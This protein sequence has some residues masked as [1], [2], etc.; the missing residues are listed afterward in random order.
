MNKSLHSTTW[1]GPS[2]QKENK[3]KM[4][5]RLKT[6]ETYRNHIDM[7]L[8]KSFLG[9]L[10][11]MMFLSCLSTLWNTTVEAGEELADSKSKMS[12]SRRSGGFCQIQ[13]AMLSYTSF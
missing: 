9:L 1:L 4:D 12:R 3:N 11:D 5:Q 6:E 13:D 2:W 8:S 10:A 7:N